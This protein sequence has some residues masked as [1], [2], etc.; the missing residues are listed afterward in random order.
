MVSCRKELNDKMY[1]SDDHDIPD[2]NSMNIGKL[3][4][5]GGINSDA[6]NAAR[7]MWRLL[8]D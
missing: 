3:S 7:K 6:C 4:H 5:G 8:S 2:A 1:Q